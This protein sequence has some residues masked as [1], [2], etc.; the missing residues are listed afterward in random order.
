MG[1]VSAEAAYKDF[2]AF[3]RAATGKKIGEAKLPTG[4]SAKES[5]AICY[6]ITAPQG[7]GSFRDPEEDRDFVYQVTC[8][9]QNAGQALWMSDRA[10]SA[11]I[12]RDPNGKYLHPM[13]LAGIEPQWR[14]SDG[15][16]GPTPS[17][18]DLQETRDTYRIRLG[19]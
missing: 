14:V 8:V 2:V 13:M 17:G 11:I 4:L 6:F 16:V 12:G 9:G 5:Y 3:L 15:L 10:R 18:V 1:Q 19:E 7:S